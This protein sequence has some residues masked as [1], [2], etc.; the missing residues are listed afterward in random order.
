MHQVSTTLNRQCASSSR[1]TLT[2]LLHPSLLSRTEPQPNSPHR[3]PVLPA[4]ELRV[5]THTGSPRLACG[6]S[7][8]T[9]AQLS[10][11]L[12]LSSCG[13][14]ES[15]SRNRPRPSHPESTLATSSQVRLLRSTVSGQLR[16]A[17]GDKWAGRRRNVG[18][19]GTAEW[20]PGHQ[21]RRRLCWLLGVS[22]LRPP[23]CTQSWKSPALP[24][25]P[26]GTF[27][28]LQTGLCGWR[29]HGGGGAG[30]SIIRLG[31]FYYALAAARKLRG[32]LSLVSFY[33]KP[34]SL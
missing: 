16:L 3:R 32:R 30:A 18:P 25:I 10:M 21:R 4:P 1:K 20:F 26:R 5:V 28:G 2:A 15:C 29:G 19:A 6:L 7:L 9:T 34:R 24:C 17:E 27:L 33:N 23:G 31:F 8:I 13:Y 22:G 12:P 14:T 11:L